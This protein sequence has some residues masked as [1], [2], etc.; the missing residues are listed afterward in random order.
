MNINLKERKKTVFVNY[1]TARTSIHLNRVNRDDRSV[2]NTSW[3]NNWLE[4]VTEM[5]TEFTPAN[6]SSFK[7]NG[8]II[9]WWEN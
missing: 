8:L 7:Y 1:K 4:Q 9:K 5:K 6:Q 3:A 2:D